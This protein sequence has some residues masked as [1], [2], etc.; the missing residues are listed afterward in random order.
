[1]GEDFVPYGRQLVDEDDIRTVCEVLRS[2]WLTTGPL[3]ERFEEALAAGVGA[4][5]CVVF[6][7]GT[8]A[9][10][11]AYFAAGVTAGDEVITTPL[12]FAATAN[13]ALYLGARP[14]FV[15]IAENS[16]NINVDKIGKAISSRSRVIAPVDLGGEPAQLDKIMEIARENGLVVV[17]DACHALGALYKG[18]RVGSI[19][20]MAVFSF[21]PVKHITTGEGGAVTTDNEDYYRKLKSFRS[22]GIVR[23]QELMEGLPLGSENDLGPWYYEQQLLGYNYRL[24]DIHC[25]LGLSQLKKLDY[26][27]KRR[28]EIAARYDEAFSRHPFLMVPPG[29][30]TGAK[31]SLSFSGAEVVSGAVSAWH[32]YILR[33]KGEKPD[34]HRR[35]V[36]ELLRERGIGTQVHYLP[37]YLHPYYRS[38]GYLPGLCPHAEDYYRRAFSIPIFP[39]MTGEEVE[40]VVDGVL[41]AAETVANG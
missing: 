37:V 35:Q 16:F 21:H 31:K 32:L 7:S 9:L 8:A 22:H 36:V 1:M 26:F 28:R 10:H 20:D 6:S 24:S 18:E 29:G 5:F 2:S 39:A 3:V 17:E 4:R 15:D 23:E 25:A 33:L 19:S 30:S 11:G 34:R 27:L 40:R 13:A 38:L 12:T 14:V 41:W